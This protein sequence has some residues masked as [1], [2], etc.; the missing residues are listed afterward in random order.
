MPPVS[1]ALLPCLRAVSLR[2]LHWKTP[3]WFIVF[4]TER[5]LRRVIDIR[6]PHILLSVL[7]SLIR[8]WLER[9]IKGCSRPLK[10]FN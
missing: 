10:R 1:L 2:R 3:A 5:R 8:V 9:V 7:D 4:A 6:K